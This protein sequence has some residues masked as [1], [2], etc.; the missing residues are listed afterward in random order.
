MYSPPSAR[1]QHPLTC[2]C[3]S[4]PFLS[5][6]PSYS[7]WHFPRAPSPLLWLLPWVLLGASRHT[8]VSPCWGWGLAKLMWGGGFQG[9][10]PPTAMLVQG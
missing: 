10:T 7:G 8:L 1:P 2:S 5:C 3:T 9:F 6:T 4:L